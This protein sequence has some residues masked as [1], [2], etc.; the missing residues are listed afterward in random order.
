MAPLLVHVEA[1]FQLAVA[2]RVKAVTKVAKSPL[3]GR[4]RGGR[5]KLR[6][7]ESCL[8]WNLRL[9][10]EARRLCECTVVEDQQVGKLDLPKL[11]LAEKARSGEV[12]GQNGWRAIKFQVSAA[13]QVAQSHLRTDALQDNSSSPKELRVAQIGVRRYPDLRITDEG[14]ADEL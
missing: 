10:V 1:A 9:F 5:Q 3:V 12:T 4:S 11:S 2:L 8:L 6:A 14:R 13:P 7:P